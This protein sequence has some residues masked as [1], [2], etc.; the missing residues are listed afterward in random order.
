M[1]RHPERCGR[2]S[3]MA[4]LSPI[5]P[6]WAVWLRFY[7]AIAPFLR[8]ASRRPAPIER[9]VELSMIGFARW[10]LVRSLPWPYLL[11]ETNFDNDSDHYLETFAL[12]IPGGLR[13][14]WRGA[15]GFP[16][17][18][19]VARFQKYVNDRKLRIYHYYSAYPTA[20]AGD[21]QR[22][23]ERVESIRDPNARVIA[24]RHTSSHSFMIPIEQ[25]GED[26]VSV[27][28]ELL[29]DAP[30]PVPPETHFARWTLIDRL[31]VAPKQ[32][33][34]PN[35]YLL[36]SAWFDG[37]PQQYFAALHDTLGPRANAIYR[38]CGFAGGDGAAFA[39]FLMPHE[40]KPGFKFHAYDGVTVAE[41]KEALALAETFRR[42]VTDAQGAAPAELQQRWAAAFPP[43]AAFSPT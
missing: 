8:L 36:F 19:R 16:N 7:F 37:P 3:A 6:I 18:R 23:L 12:V 13:V 29:K 26:E 28:I 27:G 5:R 9:L 21:Y 34:N 11:F 40:V 38:R 17:P 22:L 30:T 39:R 35:R 20:F 4:T 25:G 2:W 24:K 41:V 15:Y 32:P 31:E 10:S 42:F 14:N 43:P 1:D 33:P